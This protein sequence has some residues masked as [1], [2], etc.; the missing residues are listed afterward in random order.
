MR[1]ST[2]TPTRERLGAGP[3]SSR[4]DPWHVIVLNDHH[5]TFDG[6]AHALASV[7]SGTSFERGLQLANVIHSRGRAT[8]WSGH[9]EAAEHYWSQLKDHGLTMAPLDQA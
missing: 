5:N 6:V 4:D 9:R 1:A 7:I 8:V 2:Q 3:G